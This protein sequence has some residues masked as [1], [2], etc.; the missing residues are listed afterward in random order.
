MP[1]WLD[2]LLRAITP[3]LVVGGWI[4]VYQLQALQARRKLLRE[5]ADKARSAVYAVHELAVQFHTQDHDASRRVEVMRAV[6]D[7]ERRRG[8][9]EQIARP[10]RIMG[11]TV[12]PLALNATAHIDADLVK[13]LNQAITL[14]HFDD[15]EAKAIGIGDAQIKKIDA[16]CADLVAAVDLVVIAGLD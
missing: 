15:P 14:E 12:S 9:L 8:M 7:I 11:C 6:T 4:V 10:K 1:G 16:A 5:E 2:F 3:F 13:R